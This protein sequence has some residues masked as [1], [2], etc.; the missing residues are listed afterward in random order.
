[1]TIYFRIFKHETERAV[2]SNVLLGQ[3]KDS[4]ENWQ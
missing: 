3:G 2:M 4:C 1:M